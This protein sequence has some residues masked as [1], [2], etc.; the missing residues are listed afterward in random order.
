MYTARHVNHTH[1]SQTT[2]V[3]CTI[4]QQA[5]QQTQ[6]T[7]NT[8]SKFHKNQQITNASNGEKEKM[9]ELNEIKSATIN[10]QKRSV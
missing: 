7:S 9:I 1:Y 3:E 8:I 2:E 10:T 5:E 4:A 6:S